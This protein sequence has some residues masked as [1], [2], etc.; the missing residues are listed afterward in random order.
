MVNR[1]PNSL[2]TLRYLKQL[3]D[4]AVVVL[5]NHDLHLLAIACGAKHA[6]KKDTLEAILEA[7]DRDELLTWLRFQPLLH[8]SK[9]HQAVLV[10]AGLPPAWTLPQ[11]QLLA[12]EVEAVLRGPKYKQF[13]HHMYGNL[14]DRWQDELTGWPRLRLITNYLTRMRLCA[15]DGTLN[16]THNS[17]LDSLP[18]GFQPWFAHPH[19]LTAHNT[20]LFGHWAALEG[21]SNA[22]QVIALDTGCVWGGRLTMLRLEDHRFFSCDCPVQKTA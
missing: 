18:E 20:I 21:E 8:V 15:A 4:H 5:G 7:P 13:L 1:G 17:G 6:G 19:R 9:Q 12:A 3:D 22:N 16:L 2:E 14:P 10:H 11:A